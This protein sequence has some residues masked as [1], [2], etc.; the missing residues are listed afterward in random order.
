MRRANVDRPCA[1]HD[2]VAALRKSFDNYVWAD[3]SWSRLQLL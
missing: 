1:R 3:Q 2:W